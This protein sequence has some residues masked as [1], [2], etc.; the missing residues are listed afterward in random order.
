[1]IGERQQ[2]WL[3]IKGEGG[4]SEAS[5]HCLREQVVGVGKVSLGRGSGLDREPRGATS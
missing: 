1:M 5:H 4:G 2:G 3:D